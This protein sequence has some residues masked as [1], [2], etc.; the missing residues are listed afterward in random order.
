MQGQRHQ[1][2]PVGSN[3]TEKQRSV[4]ARHHAGTRSEV[5]PSASFG[6]GGVMQHGMHSFYVFAKLL[7]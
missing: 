7:F 5:F 6:F 2:G 3:H 4:Y 1:S